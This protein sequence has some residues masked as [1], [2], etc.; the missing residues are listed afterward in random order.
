MR[1]TMIITAIGTRIMNGT[2]RTG[3]MKIIPD[4]FTTIIPNGWRYIPSGAS[5]TAT[6]TKPTSGMI[7]HGG[8]TIIRTGFA[9]IIMTG[10]DGVTSENWSAFVFSA[11]TCARARD[12]AEHPGEVP[13]HVPASRLAQFFWLREIISR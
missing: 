3:G 1:I 10:R 4:G 5:M 2:T 12:Q 7:V 8:T 6:M 11:L 13:L 9:N